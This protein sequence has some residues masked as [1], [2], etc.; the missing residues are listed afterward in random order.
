MGK[1]TLVWREKVLMEGIFLS[2]LSYLVS[3]PTRKIQPENR[4]CFDITAFLTRLTLLLILF[5]CY[6]VAFAQVAIHTNVSTDQNSPSS[7]IS[8]PAFSTS[9]TNQLLLALIATDT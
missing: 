3:I 6:R 5:G 9:A 7:N 8:S 1:I 4:I 2:H